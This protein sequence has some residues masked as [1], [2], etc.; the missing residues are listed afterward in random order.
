MATKTGTFII[1]KSNREIAT[2][3]RAGHI[4]ART[5]E[6]LREHTKPGVTTREL[7]ALAEMAI[8]RENAIP[9]FKGYKNFPAALCLSVNEEIV[10]GIP[11]KRVLKDGD[12]LSID[13]GVIYQGYQGDSAT[14]LPV[15]TIGPVAQKLLDD[16]E[17]ALF[18][19]IA[20]ATAGN[21]LFDIS[22][23]IELEAARLGYGLVREYVGH[24]IG[25]A[26]HEDPQ[27]PNWGEPGKGPVLRAGMTLAIEP[28]FTTGTHETEQL[29]DGWTVVT[30]DRGL[31]AHFEHTV[32]I[33][34]NGP[35]I[36]TRQ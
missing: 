29:S 30:K 36:L 26:M 15:G 17:A 19:G 23:A 22:H 7:N 28:M 34:N 31:S 21:H 25:R 24:G 10:H 13:L 27:V 5:L 11:G 14:T 35:D 3:R 1:L 12:I 9:S 33:T 32:A 6:L 20:Q 4:V 2:M 18:R 16:T 8:R